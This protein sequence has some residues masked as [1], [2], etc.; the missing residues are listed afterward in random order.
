MLNC[1]LTT[2][3]EEKRIQLSGQRLKLRDMRMLDLTRI[4]V[5]N[6]RHILRKG[7]APRMKILLILNSIFLE[8]N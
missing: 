5:I 3:G 2:A 8:E 7:F 1:D 6:D 4:K